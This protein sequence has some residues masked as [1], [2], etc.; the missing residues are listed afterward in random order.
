[1]RPV[2]CIIF[3]LKKCYFA[4]KCLSC[5][6]KRC[7]FEAQLLVL[8]PITV[9]RLQASL[10]SS[11]DWLNHNHHSPCAQSIRISWTK[12]Y[13]SLTLRHK[14]TVSCHKFL[15][16]ISLR[17][18]NVKYERLAT[19]LHV[20]AMRSRAACWRQTSTKENLQS[21]PSHVETLALNAGWHAR[22]TTRKS[23]AICFWNAFDLLF[24]LQN[25]K[26]FEKQVKVFPTRKKF[27]WKT[28]T[29]SKWKQ[30]RFHL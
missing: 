28:K 7:I 15:K 23:D 17:T 24:F 11:T 13:L 21:K 2:Q 4:T 19:S 20:L 9:P 29:F 18:S 14:S 1:M 8:Q 22:A 3:H 12:R 30:K 6:W 26:D 16:D 25:E 10:I 27:F 5:T